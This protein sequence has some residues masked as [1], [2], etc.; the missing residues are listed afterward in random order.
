[1]AK[2]ATEETARK[3]VK[4]RDDGHAY[5]LNNNVGIIANL[6]KV[7]AD[8]EEKKAGS[9]QCL[10]L[11][12]MTLSAAVDFSKKRRKRYESK[13]V[14]GKLF[15]ELKK[16]GP[17]SISSTSSTSLSLDEDLVFSGFENHTEL[18]SHYKKNYD[19]KLRH[20]TDT[21][22]IETETE[23]VCHGMRMSEPFTEKGG[24]ELAKAS[25][26]YIVTNHEDHLP[27]GCLE[28]NPLRSFPWCVYD[29]LVEIKTQNASNKMAEVCEE[30]H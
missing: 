3:K 24:D 7:F 21:F 27:K 22:E 6:H 1:M 9:K 26:W 8:K 16:L 13:T 17:P 2:R 15:K 25:A 30:T 5:L 23:F 20:L 4:K 10:E 19:S 12:K 11:A 28:S 29:K 14:I 18:E